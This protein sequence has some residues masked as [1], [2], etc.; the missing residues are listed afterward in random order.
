MNSNGSAATTTSLKLQ[1][2]IFF[3]GRCQEALDYYKGVFG[4]TYEMTTVANGPMAEQ[5]PPDWQDKVMHASFT[6]GDFA[7]LCADGRPPA[8]PIDPDA[9]NIDLCITAGSQAD[10]ERVCNALADG[11]SVTMPFSKQFWGGHFGMVID[12]FGITWMVAAD[13]EG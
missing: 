5:A 11:G 13:P 12:K 9:G 4:G 1:P 8:R 10:G 7:F 3:A 2:Y 6:S